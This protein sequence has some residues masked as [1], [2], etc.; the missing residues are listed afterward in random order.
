[1]HIH[2]PIQY[3]YAYMYIHTQVQGAD[4]KDLVRHQAQWAL[5]NR[6]WKTAVSIYLT[7]EEYSKAVD[8]MVEHKVC[9]YV[10]VYVCMV[11][12]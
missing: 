9:M 7:S 4:V 5:D 6:D 8:I 11:Y 12:I 2:T 1:M 10:C 3:T